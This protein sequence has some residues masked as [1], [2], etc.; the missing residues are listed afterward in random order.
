[1]EEGATH[2]A[3]GHR[4]VAARGLWGRER[5]SGRGAQQLGS[6]DSAGLVSQLRL[7]SENF[8]NFNHVRRLETD[9]THSPC[10]AVH[11]ADDGGVQ[12]PMGNP[13]RTAVVA[14]CSGR[15]SVRVLRGQVAQA[16]SQDG[17]KPSQQEEREVELLG[18]LGIGLRSSRACWTPSGVCH[19]SEQGL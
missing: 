15:G 13:A 14:S 8:L 1:M 18:K 4:N 9:K 11:R 7:R 5:D 3:E 17:P 12:G 10:G 16:L 19:L 6:S 2:R